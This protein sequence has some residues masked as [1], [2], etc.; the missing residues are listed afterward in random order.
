MAM[1]ISEQARHEISP[2]TTPEEDSRQLFAK[3]L[4]KHVMYNLFGEIHAVFDNEVRPSYLA[5]HGEDFTSREAV[6]AAM[7]EHGFFRSA[8]GLQRISQELL[9]ASVI[10]AVER[11]ASEINEKARRLSQ[12]SQLGSLALD[13]HVAVPDYV[14]MVDIHLMPGNYQGEFTANDFSQ[15]AVFERGAYLYNLGM[16]GPHNDGIGRLLAQTIRQ[17]YPD[18][19][20]VRILDMGCTTGHQ[21]LPFCDAFPD[22]VVHAIDVAAPM[23]RYAH[24]RATALEKAVHW[25]QMDATQTTFPDGHFDLV[26]SNI[27]LHET[28]ADAVPQVIKEC[29]R[30]LRP[31]GVMAHIDIPDYN[32]YPDL[33]F[34]VVVD[35]DTFHNN[36]PFWGKLH[37]IDQVAEARQAG[38]D[39]ETIDKGIAP[40][41]SLAWSLLVARKAA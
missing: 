3:D 24:A 6:R 29:F 14:S 16:M 9:W 20:P 12:Q 11:Q 1:A 36:E 18:L 38:F 30:L 8:Q 2:V 21:T 26:V 32:K 34:Q 19:S 31:G 37:D 10:P 17:R 7:W 13:P 5:S 33:L 41:G 22:A 4:R 23:L 28:C 27:M 40:M 39:P 35:A 25:H 15:G